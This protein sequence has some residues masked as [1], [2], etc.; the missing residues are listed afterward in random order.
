MEPSASLGFF[1]ARIF[2]SNF[3]VEYIDKNKNSSKKSVKIFPTV[4]EF[5]HEK[6]EID[7][8]IKLLALVAQDGNS[9]G[10]FLYGHKCG[11]FARYFRIHDNIIDTQT[12]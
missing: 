5:F 12:H 4:P 8:L 3:V 9:N 10:A 11:L 7:I 6:T 1:Q 2:D